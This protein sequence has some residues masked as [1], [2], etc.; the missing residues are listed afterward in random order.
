MD[1]LQSSAMFLDLI[2]T[3]VGFALL[4]WGA[5]RFSAGAGAI[6]R[7]MGV[8]PVVIGLTVVAFATSAPEIMVS[9]SAAREGLT[10]MAVGNALG[11]NIANI[12]LVLAISALL[13]PVGHDVSATLRSELP[14]LLGVSLGTGVLLLDNELN[15]SDG[16]ILLVGLTVFLYWVTRTGQRVRRGDPVIAEATLELPP[17]MPAFKAS[18][19][20]L[21]GFAALLIGAELLVTGA[22]SIARAFG[23]SDLIIGLTVVAVGTS[24]PELAVTLVSAMRG[25]AGLA[26]GNVI[27]SN[28]FN[29]LAVIGAAGIVGPGP[30]DASVISLHYPVM[31]LFT[32]ALLR[33]TYNPFGS[34]GFGRVMGLTLLA[35][36][37]AYQGYLLSTAL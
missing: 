20:L 11:S 26:V 12:G 10:G 17:T 34:P 15:L 29:L 33:L 13:K 8:S 1:H 16:I 36:F 30:L 7:L 2:Y 14:L 19:M 21:I 3:L 35:G 5:D 6:A 37:V 32:A 28:V 25:E 27:G 22:E 31:L 4:I 23:V 24:L 9:I 18:G